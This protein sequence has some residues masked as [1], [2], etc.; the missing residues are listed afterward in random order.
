MI[1]GIRAPTGRWTRSAAVAVL[2]LAAGGA[3]QCGADTATAPALRVALRADAIRTDQPESYL[4]SG[5]TFAIVARQSPEGAQTLAAVVNPS[6]PSVF[7][8]RLADRE[9]PA[10]S[11]TVEIPLP[12]GPSDAPPGD[13][14]AYDI[15]LMDDRNGNGAWEEGE[16]FVASW[17]GGR[18]GYRLVYLTEAAARVAAAAPGWNLYEGGVPPAH[19]A[20]V[21]ETTVYLYPVIEPVEQR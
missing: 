3:A 2:T 7:R 12:A 1:S 4:A 17:S 15:V 6:V 19:H 11:P 16:P 5:S 18:G 20:P 14:V 9:L 21:G 10:T 8:Q 13:A